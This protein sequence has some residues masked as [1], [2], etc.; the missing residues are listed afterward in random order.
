M[1]RPRIHWRP[2]AP[3]SYPSG[4]GRIRTFVLRD[5]IVCHAPGVADWSIELKW[6]T[7][8]R[9]LRIGAMHRV[10]TDETIRR[11]LTR[12]DVLLPGEEQGR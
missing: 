8:K 2:S 6:V 3:I 12:E 9:C 11:V 10:D 5:N 4:P 7:C 1:A